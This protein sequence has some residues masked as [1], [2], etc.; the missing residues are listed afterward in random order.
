MPRCRLIPWRARA[1]SPHPGDAPMAAWLRAPG[2]LTA[3]LARAF[4]PVTVER[5]R[6]GAGRAR[7]DEAAAL[8]LARGRRVHV[9]EV[10]LRCGGR[11]PV[12]ARSVCE[13]RHLR[14]A[15]RALK[16]LG[17]RPLA[18]LLFSDRRVR[19]LPMS[20]SRLAPHQPRGRERIAAWERAAGRAWPSVAGVSGA[21]ARR[22]VF[23]RRGAALLVAEMFSA[24]VQVEA[25]NANLSSFRR[26]RRP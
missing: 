9:R 10:L 21:W 19:R 3:H 2:S 13:A 26:C 22:S 23:Q 25:P 17:S 6:Q 20:F 18:L 5:L 4:G 11:A 8:G 24:E 14:G 12:M 7:A 15:W 16:G 1:R